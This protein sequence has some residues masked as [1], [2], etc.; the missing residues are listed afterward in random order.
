MKLRLALASSLLALA[1][2]AAPAQGAVKFA[3]GTPYGSTDAYNGVVAADFDGDGDNDIAYV[4]APIGEDLRSGGYLG[5]RKNDGKGKFGEETRFPADEGPTAIAVGD[6]NGDGKPDVVVTA[7]EL[8]SDTVSVHINTGGAFAAPVSYRS[9]GGPNAVDLGD[10][11]GDGDLDVAVGGFADP[12]RGPGRPPTGVAIHR[13]NGS[14]ALSGAEIYPALEEGEPFDV[15]I[16]DYNGDGQRDVAMADFNFGLTGKVSVFPGT[17]G[18]ALGPQT[19]YDTPGSASDL[20]T[21]KLNGDG[22]DDLVV[23]SPDSPMVLLSDAG[24]FAPAR[25]YDTGGSAGEI[26]V[27][28]FDGGGVLD[29]AAPDGG[30]RFLIGK[31]GGT[32]ALDKSSTAPG[33]GRA[34]TAAD[35]NGDK[36]PDVVAASF[37]VDVYLNRTAAK[38]PRVKLSGVPKRC[39]AKRGFK[40]KVK[41]TGSVKRVEVRVDGK[42]IKRT[43]KKS[44]SVRVKG[45]GRG[46]HRVVVTA[47]GSGGKTTKRASFR[48]C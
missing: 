21:A 42:R 45:R 30:L 19:T 18:G 20:E 40:L 31:G 6:M 2:A 27:A 39:V 22:A 7:R 5:L 12:E 44:F 11:D 15:E 48:R 10:I 29:I 24:G 4:A 3:E 37:G 46:K 41:A 43:S 38:K 9:A 17:G 1:A 26:A 16:G 36:R 8:T 28:D 33:G 14:G 23:G 25:T 34:L 13:N 35:L 47:T 32:F